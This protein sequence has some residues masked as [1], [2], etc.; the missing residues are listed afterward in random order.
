VAVQVLA[1]GAQHNLAVLFRRQDKLN[2]AASLLRET[3]NGQR[4][5]VGEFHSKALGMLGTLDQ[6]LQQM[7][8]FDEA[9]APLDDHHQRARAERGDHDVVS[10]RAAIRLAACDEAALGD[11]A[12]TRKINKRF[13]AL[14]SGE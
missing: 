9:R 12:D 3:L 6:V 1:L 14:T 5:T 10:I 13:E 7:E 2:D 8:R 4:R 11:T